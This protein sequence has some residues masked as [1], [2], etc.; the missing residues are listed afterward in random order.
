MDL[1]KFLV[2]K[3][4]FGIKSK[5][6]A[7]RLIA[8]GNVTVNAITVTAIDH[9]LNPGDDVS[10]NYMMDAY[11][12]PLAVD[13]VWFDFQSTEPT[14][15]FYVNGAIQAH[16]N[17]CDR[18]ADGFL[19]GLKYA[20]VEFKRAD[21]RIHGDNCAAIVEL[22]EKPPKKWPNKYTKHVVKE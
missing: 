2:G 7:K 5:S 18:W 17:N 12:P 11:V 4:L 1:V 3:K 13:V 15:A 14:V 16:G 21:H 22:G 10:Y 6:E 20:K 9:V 8:T 19:D